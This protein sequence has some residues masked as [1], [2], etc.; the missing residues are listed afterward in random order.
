MVS[1]QEA[2][3]KADLE[4]DLTLSATGL[5]KR[6]PSGNEEVEVLHGIDLELK[7]GEIVA[8]LGPSGAGK[9]TLLHLLGLMEQ[10]TAGTLKIQGQEVQTLSAKDRARLRNEYIG[11]LF[12]FHHLLPELNVLE[13]VMLPQ[14]I[15][16]VS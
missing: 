4:S 12:Q 6:F 8:I 2:I 3:S 5:V 1:L 9:S 14:R 7:E 16:G 10:P 11:F 13:N 15:L